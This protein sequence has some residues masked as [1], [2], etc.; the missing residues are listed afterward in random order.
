MSAIEIAG[1]LLIMLGVL[2]MFLRATGRLKIMDEDGE[3]GSR[4]FTLRGGPGLILVGLGVFL[5][6]TSA[7]S[8][9]GQMPATMPPAEPPAQDPGSDSALVVSDEAVE[10]VANLS[11]E[12]PGLFEP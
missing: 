9:P 2:Y 6:V 8:E 7:V 10:E 12:W 4:I 11:R 5:L 3:L 1:I